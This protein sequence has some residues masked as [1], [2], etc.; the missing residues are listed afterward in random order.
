MSV[1]FSFR[2]FF[3]PPNLWKY[4]KLFEEA[5]W[6]PPERLRCYQSER[7][8]AVLVH[9][10]ARVPY[11]RELFRQEGIRPEDIRGT[12]DL[13]RM[14]VLAKETLRRRFPSLESE[15]SRRY[16]PQLTHTSGTT[17]GRIAFLLD[18]A[19]NA[20]E[21]S[22]YRRYWGWAGYRL[23]DR[24]AEFS[25]AYFRAHPGRAARRRSWEA[26]PWI[27]RLL[28]NSL[29]LS[30]ESAPVLA[31]RL[32]R[33]RAA[34]LKGM[35]SILYYFALFLAEK[36]IRLSLRAVFSTGETLTDHQRR[37]IENGFGC[38]VTDSYGHMERIVA[39]SEC[40]RGRLHVNSDYGLMEFE[41]LPGAGSRYSRVLATGLHNR[42]M[43]LV[44]YDTGDIAEF[45][46][47]DSPCP[48]G[49]G[50]PVIRRIHGRQGDPVLTP[51]GRV[52]T[53]L[54][55]VFG[56]VEGIEAGQIVQDRLDHLSVRVV[57]GADW[58][59]VSRA[60]LTERIS[61]VVGGGVRLDFE[62]TDLR[63]L[64]ENAPSKFKAVRSLLLPR[65]GDPP[66]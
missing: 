55:L 8:R 66:A 47:A 1:Q 41:P 44:R 63:G 27:G 33:H 50:F 9:A 30:A 15:D 12:E 14:P 20:M 17:G 43:P 2:G 59:E 51:D 3:D 46:P 26:Q 54:F 42:S 13:A 23:G 19:T 16:K 48:C 35:S 32:A 22:Y 4:A 21:F 7:L 57:P 25:S 10:A 29:E 49:R 34:F 56:E 31:A 62:T 58:S 37:V 61:G 5:Q 39:A 18:R 6:W 65:D 38:R 45:D 53:T 60:R 36:G 64:G 40:P 52:V 11:Y 28:L 24:F